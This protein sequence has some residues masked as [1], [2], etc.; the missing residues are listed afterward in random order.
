MIRGHPLWRMPRSH[1]LAGS[2]AYTSNKNYAASQTDAR[3]KVVRS[4]IDQTLGTLKSVTDPKGQKVNYTYDQLKRVTA[5][6]AAAGGKNYKNT[7]AYKDGRLQEAAH[8]TTGDGC[9]VKYTFGYDAAGRPTMVKVGTQTLSTNAYNADG[10][11]KSVTYGN[12]GKAN[13]G[14]DA[15]KRV[16]SLKYDGDSRMQCRYAYG[17]NGQVACEYDDILPNS[18]FAML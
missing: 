13:Y 8:N 7:Y 18:F 4:D 3:G 5:V 10:T 12:G 16:T 6:S 17:A 2:T 9:D 15:F 11:L 1:F 14:Y